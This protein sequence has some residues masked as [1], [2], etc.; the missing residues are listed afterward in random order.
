MANLANLIKDILKR[1]NANID[2][3]PSIKSF[4]EN[5]EIAKIE[6]SNEDQTKVLGGIYNLETARIALKPEMMKTAKSELLDGLDSQIIA[7]IGDGL[8]EDDLNSVKSE[9]D[10]IK[11]LRLANDAKVKALEAKLKGAKKDG[12]S[13]QEKVLREE[14]NSLNAQTKAKIEEYDKTIIELKNS[15]K[16]EI[17]NLGLKSK[18]LSRTD[19]A[20]ELL[21]QR[22]FAQNFEADM[23]DFAKSKGI[24][25]D[26]ESGKILKSETETDFLDDKGNPTD[27]DWMIANVVKEFKYEKKS[28]TPQKGTETIEKFAVGSPEYI[29]Q[30]TIAANQ[31]MNA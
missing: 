20:E 30:Q 23:N 5:P 31:A 17:F 28:E 4:L 19:I 26:Y 12:D 24:K 10:T 27:L 13:D 1:S 15:H 18:I 25:I 8:S 6:V 3:V 21:K 7:I 16:K 22:H 11:K 29:R 2:D 14:I 9:K